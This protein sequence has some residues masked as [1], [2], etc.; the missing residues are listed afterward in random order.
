VRGSSSGG[1][2]DAA[3]V[4]VK[5]A[6]E[7]MPDPKVV[8]KRT[9]M[10]AG[11]SGSSPPHKQFCTTWTYPGPGMLFILKVSIFSLFVWVY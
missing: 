7:A 10:A 2:P 5:M 11:S 9:A 8:T 1:R 6:P 4:G 3:L